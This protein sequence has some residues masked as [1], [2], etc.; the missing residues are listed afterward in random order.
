LQDVIVILFIIQWLR[1]ANH[2]CNLK[3]N[4]KFIDII[5]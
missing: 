4:S 3:Q 1:I 5:N 2:T